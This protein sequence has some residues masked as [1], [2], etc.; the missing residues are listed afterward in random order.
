[1]ANST[2]LRPTIWN[3]G[4][5]ANRNSRRQADALKRTWE[6]LDFLPQAEPSATFT[7]RTLRQGG[8]V[9]AG[10][11]DPS[12]DGRVVCRAADACVIAAVAKS[13]GQRRRR[14]RV[15]RRRF[16]PV[17][18]AGAQDA[19]TR[20]SQ[21]G[22]RTDGPGLRVLDNLPLYQYAD[23]LNFVFGLDQSD[24]FGDEVNH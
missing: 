22:R 18:A 2:G 20:R 5:V 16:W 7:S 6:L 23:D 21:A 12:A 3:N 17:R 11:L 15:V 24:L 19:Q 10:A 14:G 8:G 1:M 9:A 4:W 13:G